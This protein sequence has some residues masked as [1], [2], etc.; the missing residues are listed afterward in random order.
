MNTPTNLHK[1]TVFSQLLDELRSQTLEGQ[2]KIIKVAGEEDLRLMLLNRY[3]LRL[4]EMPDTMAAPLREIERLLPDIKRIIENYKYRYIH[5]LIHTMV[6]ATDEEEAALNEVMQ[7]LEAAPD[8]SSAAVLPLD[9]RIPAQR[10]KLVVLVSTGKSKEAIG[11]QLT[12]DQVKRLS[13]ND[14][15]KYFKRYETYVGDKSTESLIDSA[16]MLFSKGA[17]LV[18]SIDDVK[19][20]QKELNSDYIINQELSSL[21][22]GLALRFGRWLALANAALITT[23]HIKFEK[24]PEHPSR[25]NEGYPPTHPSRDSEG[26]PLDRFDEVDSLAGT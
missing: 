13:D 25:N 1:L 10:E 22:G 21:A 15:Q 9:D 17:G 19:E 4:T 6:H 12:R 14:V 11:V 20:L 7:M 3:P 18:I 2:I 26:Y 23:K 8:S 5:I 24:E 16:I